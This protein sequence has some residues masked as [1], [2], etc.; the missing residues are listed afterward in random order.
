MKWAV[1]AAVVSLSLLWTACSKVEEPQ[2]SPPPARPV[3]LQAIGYE[4]VPPEYGP[5]VQ[6]LRV[7]RSI[8]VRAMP[9]ATA[10]PLGTVAQD[11]RV[12]WT[13]AAR[14]PGCQHLW[15]EIAPRGWVCDAYLQPNV[16][17]PRA[18]ELP[19]L[20][21]DSVVPGTYGKIRERAR[22]FR[23]ASDARRGVRGR[24]T[25]DAT[26][27][28]F[29]REIAIGWKRFWKTATGE[30]VDTRKIVPRKPSLFSGVQLRD[31]RSPLLPFAFVHSAKPVMVWEE[32]EE[33]IEVG[34][35]RPRAVVPV[36][37]TSEDGTMVRLAHERWIE[38]DKLRIARMMPPPPEVRADE[39]WIDIDL[40]EQVLVAYEGARPVFATL[41][42]TGK[43][44][45]T[46][47]GTFR[48]WIKFAE[49]QMSG[50]VNGHSYLVEDVPWTMFFQGDFALHA[51]Y[52]HDHFG[53]PASSG[54]VNLAPRD[55]RFLYQWTGPEVPRGWTMA[56]ATSDSPGTLVRIRN[57]SPTSGAV[58]TATTGSR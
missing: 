23:S 38:A 31:P 18:L 39:K 15:I 14:G 53:N 29:A 25:A 40:A 20:Q 2:P 24:G 12:L 45:A 42:S 19:R 7:L 3:S 50:E 58:A 33:F 46:P 8:V 56:N 44:N 55:A 51:A 34:T 37:G 1:R 6:S 43:H 13:R 4:L 32:P 16:R 36:M 52:W 49:R 26:M 10:A 48:I 28:R 57:G 30:L 47:T 27:V 9:S 41:V 35:L 22:V 5:K 54:C 21:D 17:G 11:T